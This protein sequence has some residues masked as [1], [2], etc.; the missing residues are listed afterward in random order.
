MKASHHIMTM[1]YLRIVTVIVLVS[2]LPLVYLLRSYSVEATSK[3]RDSQVAGC[4]RRVKDSLD[5]IRGWEAAR[6]ARLNSVRTSESPS[7][8]RI[9]QRAADNYTEIITSLRSRLVDCEAAFP[10]P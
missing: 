2:V 10:K 7:E 5:N 4:E 9:S 1:A 8:R 3:L 6:Q